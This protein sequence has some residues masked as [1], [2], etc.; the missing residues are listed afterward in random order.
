M[1]RESRREVIARFMNP[2]WYTEMYNAEHDD[3]KQKKIIMMSTN[4]MTENKRNIFLSWR[5]KLA[6][7]KFFNLFETPVLR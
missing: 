4:N 1:P 3:P 2:W 6:A 5:W 7:L